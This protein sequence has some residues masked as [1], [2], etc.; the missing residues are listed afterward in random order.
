M[1]MMRIRMK[2]D[3]KRMRSGGE[4][5]REKRGGK[6]WRKTIGMKEREIRR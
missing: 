6:K 5:G 3:E 4:S 1:Y 2:R